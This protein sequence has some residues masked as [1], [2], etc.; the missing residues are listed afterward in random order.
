M[1]DFPRRPELSAIAEE[2]SMDRDSNIGEDGLSETSEDREQLRHIAA[3][4]QEFLDTGDASPLVDLLADDVQFLPPG[5]STIDGKDAVVALLEEF[6]AEAFDVDIETEDV[7]ISGD[8][9]VTWGHLTGTMVLHEGSEPEEGHLTGLGVYRRD[10]AG[11]W[12]QTLA[13]W[14]ESV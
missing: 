7:L 10:D 9:A 4:W 8:M 3:A 5:G 1:R 13:I 14:N 6:P 11:K 12:K 2:M